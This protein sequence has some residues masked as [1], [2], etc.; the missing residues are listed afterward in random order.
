MSENSELSG[1][2]ARF[3][4]LHER[5]C[6][7]IP[8]PWDAGTTRYLESLGFAALAS[9][10]AGA[11]FSLGLPDSQWAV[12]RSAMLAHIQQIVDSTSLPVNADFENGYA[13]DPAGVAEGVMLCV[14]TGVAGLSI[15]DSTGDPAN[16]LYELKRGAERIEAARKAIDD[17]K[18]GVLLTGRAECYLTGHPEPLKE[19]L[20]RLEAYAAAG[21]D[22][23]YAPGAQDPEEIRAIV[24]AVSPKPVNVLMGSDNGL[25]VKDLEELGARRIS[26]GSSLARAAWDGFLRAS[27]EIAERGTFG[28]FK[29]IVS[30]KE[31]NTF[32]QQDWERRRHR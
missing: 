11:A 17:T 9:T 31:L 24:K 21:A 20:R 7:V 22:V 13:H 27:R 23:L 2:R 32:F 19:A 10:S 16:P 3:R 28:G 5:G 1:R 4:E 8:N 14:K 29:E 12:T 26:V 25:S 30:Y 18:S 6:F 15:E